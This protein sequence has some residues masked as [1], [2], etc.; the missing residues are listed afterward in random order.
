LE[1]QHASGYDLQAHV[2]H[3]CRFH[4]GR[5]TPGELPAHIKPAEY[6]ALVRQ[7]GKPEAF[8]AFLDTYALE[9]A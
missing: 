3:F 1:R 4:A 6:P 8:A 7:L 9:A 2:V 5:M